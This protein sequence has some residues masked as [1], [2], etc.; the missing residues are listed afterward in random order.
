MKV[1]DITP[2]AE[3]DWFLADPFARGRAGHWSGVGR[4]VRCRLE[5]PKKKWKVMAIEPV[6]LLQTHLALAL[7]RK[8][9]F[10]GRGARD[11]GE[12]PKFS[13]GY[14]NYFF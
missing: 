10:T 2:H 6:R 3:L 13:R 8:R 1:S 9:L 4:I 7:T 5:R 12:N 14:V 11:G